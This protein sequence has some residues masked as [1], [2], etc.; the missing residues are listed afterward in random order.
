M[1][2]ERWRQITEVFQGALARESAARGAFIDEACAGDVSLRA[3][4]DAMLAAHS[5]AAGFGERPAIDLDH[6]WRSAPDSE[7][8]TLNAPV[9]QGRL[10]GQKL[11]HYRILER[12]GAGGM[13]EVYRAHDDELRRDVAI[14]IL[15]ASSLGDGTARARLL[16]EARAAA[17]LNHPNICTI[18]EVGEVDGQAYIAMELVDGQPLSARLERGRL[19]PAEVV[20]LALPL[21]DALAH[22]HERGVIH[23]DLKSANIIVTRTGWPK[24][25]DFGLAKR[26]AGEE[27]EDVTRS[28][29]LTEPGKVAGT[30]PYMP[31]EQLRGQPADARGDIWSLGV[32]L[33][34]MAAGVRPFQGRTGFEVVS[35][36]LNDEAPALPPDVPRDLV[37]LIDRCLAKEPAQRYET[38]REAR[39]A[40]ETV[41]A[42]V[43][44][45]PR[46][47]W[48]S[49]GELL[50]A[51]G[52]GGDTRSPR[53]RAVA[54]A[55]G[56]CVAVLAAVV[57]LWPRRDHGPGP[58]LAPDTPAKSIAVLP[59]QNLS[60]DPE[61]AYFAD[62]ITEDV[63]TQLAKIRELKVIAPTSVMRYKGS[64]K[65]VREIARE[66]GVATVL[67]G[68]V[69]RAG[70]RVR[71]TGQLI[72]ART[73][74]HLWAE[75][76]DRE[77]ADVFAIQTDVAQRIASALKASLT[78]EDRAR[79]AE[80]PTGN[81]EAYDLY[82]KGRALYYHYRKQ[83]NDQAIELF[84][85]AL[86]VDPG[87][88][89]A[90]AGLADALEQRWGRFGTFLPAD[91]EAA[92][93]A[94][95]TAVELN[96][97]L[98]EA[99]KALALTAEA[100][101]HLHEA[102]AEGRR[103][104]ELHQGTGFVAVANVGVYLSLLGR[105]DEALSWVRRSVERDPTSVA[106]VGGLGSV[107]EAIG[108]T[109][110]AEPTLRRA[111]ELGPKVGLTHVV[112]MN[113]YLRHQRTREALEV[114][115][116]A[117]N[118]VSGD[119]HVIRMAGLTELVAGNEERAKE[120]LERVLP[121]LQ[122]HRLAII[123]DAGVETYIAWLD[124]KAG[125][126]A[127]A[128]ERLEAARSA[129]QRELDGGTDF[130]AVPFDLACVSAIEGNNDEA[131]RWLQKAYDAG[132]RG[133]PQANWSPLLDPLRQDG[134]FR[135]LMRR[136][137][138]DVAA[139]RR[140]AGLG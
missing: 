35:A 29:S 119:P 131:F 83:D 135:A 99:H 63:L 38:A 42:G 8:P 108:E 128:K 49:C 19:P 87:F 94:A 100:R 15:P 70:N 40:L 20:R 126:R 62:G 82:V 136:I 39:T 134:R 18:H 89:L 86:A 68:S 17:A 117:L 23:R 64:E 79:I 77:L 92:E 109:A 132:W 44:K 104:V 72:D 138:E 5:A 36:V 48:P 1:T 102:L 75:N 58:P 114:A 28:Q 84:R 105:F 67:E 4:V 124:T 52:S 122:G 12:V 116:S 30:L 137:D 81:I 16:R 55:A 3:E 59:F 13:G 24:M 118:L 43:S 7:A 125:V 90:Q 69:R 66:L 111:V 54:A 46:D 120:L 115:R 27:L 98:P 25:L 21:A 53:R 129:D 51:F 26:L 10:A 2:P 97:Q 110:Q 113:L 78:A 127:R 85:K 103:A 121:A 33:Y 22:A 139:M 61:N 32:V 130:W 76:Y 37:A 80:R 34:E 31:P 41:Q 123:P 74:Q 133:W 95:R 65:P 96:P 93:A 11:G 57:T 112:L 14:K 107:Y 101:G 140:R 91:L 71:I 106:S 50:A 56:A 47:R 73:E 60:P 9:T 88:A 6:E 45:D